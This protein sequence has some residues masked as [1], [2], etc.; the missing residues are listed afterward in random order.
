MIACMF[1]VFF[2][3]IV[4]IVDIVAVITFCIGELQSE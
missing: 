2:I 4:G 1:H 3:D